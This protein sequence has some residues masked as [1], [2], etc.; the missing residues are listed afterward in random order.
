MKAEKNLHIIGGNSGVT[1]GIILE[2]RSVYGVGGEF[3]FRDG[4]LPVVGEDVV[5]FGIILKSVNSPVMA[6]GKDVYLKGTTVTAD[7]AEALTLS[8]ATFM[9]LSTDGF[10]DIIGQTI[11]DG[12]AVSG[13]SIVNRFDKANVI[14]SNTAVFQTTAQY[15]LLDTVDG[16]IYAGGPLAIAKGVQAYPA[17]TITTLISNYRAN[18]TTWLTGTGVGDLP[19]V[20]AY[21]STLVYGSGIMGDT[22]FIDEAGF[23]CRNEE[24]YGL[25]DDFWVVESRW[26]QMYREKEIGLLWYEP[27]VSVPG[28]TDTTTRPHPGNDYWLY[29][30]KLAE[31][32]PELWEWEAGHN[33]A[34]DVTA[35]PEDGDE[36]S[37]YDEVRTERADDEAT[38]LK[39]KILADT[40]RV[41][42]QIAG[43]EIV[44][45]T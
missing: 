25:S 3:K 22:D 7:A 8:G 5:T 36:A 15:V 33:A 9:R 34:R 18:F 14:F 30:E 13:S 31:Y 32:D 45:S 23:T 10:T 19:V 42:R 35:D 40:Y 21:T 41:S 4:D 44:P 37:V 20:L 2:S 12:T 11:A 27:P 43:I 29:Y 16:A 28:A 1:G 39:M 24:Q 38:A 17:A 6:Y 26:Q